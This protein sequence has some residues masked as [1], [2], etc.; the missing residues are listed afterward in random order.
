MNISILSEEKFL[1]ASNNLKLN[2][3]FISDA[4]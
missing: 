1:I 3:F 4:G 2:F